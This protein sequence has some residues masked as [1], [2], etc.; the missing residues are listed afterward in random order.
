MFYIC[1][2]CIF[3]WWGW[4]S[5]MNCTMVIK[6]TW[7]FYDFMHYHLTK[8]IFDL[9]IL[10]KQIVDKYCTSDHISYVIICNSLCHIFFQ[11]CPCL[12]KWCF[13]HFH[14]WCCCIFGADNFD[15]CILCWSIGTLLTEKLLSCLNLFLTLFLNTIR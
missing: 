9:I 7:I 1:R 12:C 13:Y 6:S 15:G 8:F 3:T 14:L 10:S 2:Y 11:A 5:V 4:Y